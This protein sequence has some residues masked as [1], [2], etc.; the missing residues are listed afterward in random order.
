MGGFPQARNFYVSTHVNFTRVNKIE[1]MNVSKVS[2]KHKSWTSL[3]LRLRTS[4]HIHC[5][6][7]IYARK[8]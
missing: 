3:N 7:F 8:I 2:R 5:L 4:L 6:Y 1:A